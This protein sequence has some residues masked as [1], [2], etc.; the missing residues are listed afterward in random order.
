MSPLFPSNVWRITAATGGARLKGEERD[1]SVGHC[2]YQHHSAS[3]TLRQHEL[4]AAR[5]PL[6]PRSPLLGEDLAAWE[7]ISLFTHRL[8]TGV[9]TNALT[10]DTSSSFVKY[11][12][13]KR[14][15]RGNLAKPT[16]FSPLPLGGLHR[17]SPPENILGFRRSFP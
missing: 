7:A 6:L 3:Q 4:P 15:R 2:V 11:D 8:V 10:V 14:K 16:I 12:R 13:H 1:E 5:V 17:L 9:M